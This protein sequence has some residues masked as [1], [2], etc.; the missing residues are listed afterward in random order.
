MPSENNKRFSDLLREGM[1]IKGI[2]IEQLANATGIS[3][4]FILLLLEEQFEKLPPAPYL[5][6][7][8]VKISETLD[9]D[10]ENVWK[11]FF[12]EANVVR[13]SGAN[14]SLPGKSLAGIK[15]YKKISLLLIVATIIAIYILF[16]LYEYFKT[17]ELSIRGIGDNT[18]VSEP[19]FKLNGKIE[20]KDSLILNGEQIYPSEDGTFEKELTLSPGFNTLKFEI[21]KF[22]G[23]KYTIEKQIFFEPVVTNPAQSG[24]TIPES[25][26]STGT[27]EGL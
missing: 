3:D 19:L 10:G 13:K 5:H 9:F 18:V 20:V 16:R 2:S 17:P 22:L 25:I 7:Y 8:I 15:K 21:K 12:K 14:D 6:G 1:K 24:Q 26:Y 11:E 4:R 27:P 23:K